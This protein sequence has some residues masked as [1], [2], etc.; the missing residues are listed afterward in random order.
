MGNTGDVSPAYF[1]KSVETLGLQNQVFVHGPKYGKDK[2]IYFTQ[3]DVF[4]FPTYYHGETFGLVLLEAM[5]YGLPCISTFEGGIPSVVEDAK[6][7]F[8]VPQRDANGCRITR[9]PI[10]HRSVRSRKQDL[11][12]AN[13]T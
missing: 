8:L 11:H 10:L 6:T 12:S 5:E 1:R 3:S 13:W 9:R 4:V 2:K 7:G